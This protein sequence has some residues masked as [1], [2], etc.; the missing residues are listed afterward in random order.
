MLLIIKT[1]GLREPK[2]T[3]FHLENH[4]KT[5]E[6]SRPGLI[7]LGLIDW[8]KNF[9]EKYKSKMTKETDA[10][11]KVTKKELK[12]L[13]FSDSFR[14]VKERLQQA[15]EADTRQEEPRSGPES[16]L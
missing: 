7:E 1:A 11:L 16:N 4:T 12:K 14:N 10:T 15:K 2:A 13:V 5:I 3:L 6:A 8:V 9:F